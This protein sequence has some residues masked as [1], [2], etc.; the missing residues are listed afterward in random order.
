MDYGQAIDVLIQRTTAA[1]T[2]PRKRPV[3]GRDA[4]SAASQ[5]GA[6]QIRIALPRPGPE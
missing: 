1:G 4:V 3:T 2:F 5:I 6:E